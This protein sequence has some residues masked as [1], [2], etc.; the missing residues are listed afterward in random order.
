M[1]LVITEGRSLRLRGISQDILELISRDAWH[2]DALGRLGMASALGIPLVVGGRTLGVLALTS[3]RP[4]RLRRRRGRVPRGPGA[5]D[6]DVGGQRPEL[7]AAAGD[8]ADPA[9]LA[10]AERAPDPARDEGRPPLPARHGRRGG[11][12]RLVRPDPAHPRPDRPGD[13]RRHGAGHRRRRRHGPAARG[14]ARLR[15]GRG[16]PRRGA[17]P[18]RRGDVLARP[19]VPDHLPVR[20]CS[21]RPRDAC[22]S[23]A[24]GTCRRW[25][26]TA[27]AAGSTSSSTRGRRSASPATPRPRWRC[28]CP[29]GRCCCCSPT[30]W[31]RAARSRSR[32]ACS[33]CATPWPT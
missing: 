3:S 25:S 13:R 2:L 9:A 17:R 19:D 30:G 24:P 18:G 1:G 11:R 28:C 26:C 21:T 4:R 7:P 27:T 14:R 12:R 5:P 29:T 10:A 32:A 16:Q 15:P 33:R 8:R 20:A 31:W 23:P 22:G 6:G